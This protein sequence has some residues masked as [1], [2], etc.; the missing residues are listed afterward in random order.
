MNIDIVTQYALTLTP[1][2]TAVVACVTSIVVCVS[3]VKRVCKDSEE[4]I[5]KERKA[6]EHGKTNS[7]LLKE[8]EDLRRDNIRLKS[9]NNM[10]MMKLKGVRFIE[11]E[12]GDEGV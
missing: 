8:N 5:A 6:A 12:P 7:E 10:L 11:E 2:V 1:A 3:R 9:N 4:N